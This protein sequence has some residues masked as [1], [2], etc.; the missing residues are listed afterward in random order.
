MNKYQNGK[1]YKLVSPT[2]D[3]VYIGSTIRLLKDRLKSH[4]ISKDTSARELGNDVSIVLIEEYSCNCKKELE[5]RETFWIR[6]T[7]NTINKQ[8]PRR[9]TK[10]YREDNKEIIRKKKRDDYHKDIEKSR[11]YGRLIYQNNIEK[12]REQDKLRHHRDKEKRN[13]E[14]RRRGRYELSWGGDK[15]HWNNNLLQISIDLFN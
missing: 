13:A 7:A 4:L 10:Q 9:S 8:M 1:I 2:T 15:R 14:R 5:E 3:K 6:N 12:I 11:E